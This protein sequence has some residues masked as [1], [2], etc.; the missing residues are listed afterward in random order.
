MRARLRWADILKG[1]AILFVLLGHTPGTP[2]ALKNLIYSF[3]MPLF[4]VLSGFLARPESFD[5]AFGAFLRGNVRR[6]VVPYF[7]FSVVSYPIWVASVAFGKEGVDAPYWKPLLGTLYGNGTDTYLVHNVA[8]WFFAC[9]FV[10]EILFYWVYRLGSSTRMAIALVAFSALAQIDSHYDLIR[11]PWSANVA[12]CAV[13]FYGLGFLSCR[14][15]LH[16]WMP[17][18]PAGWVLIV[19]LLSIQVGLS[20]ANG[21]VDMNG[22][23]YGSP[24]YFYGAAL[25]GTAAWYLIARLPPLEAVP[26]LQA[27]GRNT[28]VIFPL[29][30][31]LFS[32][33]TGLIVI[34]F[35][36]PSTFNDNSAGVAFAYSIGGA[37]LLIPLAS[38]LQKKAPWAIGR[39]SQ[40]GAAAP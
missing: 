17:G 8:L 2:V 26:F 18:S 23:N 5:R 12:L 10:T 36:V 19:V 31:P 33:L 37:I 34:G 15:Q 20:M 16:L 9:L 21:R 40:S 25:S 6:L 4:F 27:I 22:H 24:L 11:L 32:I 7:L 35:G 28:V 30:L 39:G 13:G 29:H 38:M 1:I 3:H 14:T